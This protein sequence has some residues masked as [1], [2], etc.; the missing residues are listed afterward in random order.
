MAA[1][2]ETQNDIYT[3][4]I[5]QGTSEEEIEEVYRKLRSAGYGEEQ[6][7]RRLEAAIMRRRN[8][9]PVADRRGS[10]EPASSRGPRGGDQAS[11]RP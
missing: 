11:P 9:Q 3:R 7:R 5:E 4:L 8:G 2:H 1:G 10:Q 6:A